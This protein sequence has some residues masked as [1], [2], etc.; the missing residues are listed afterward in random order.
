M[1]TVKAILAGLLV[2][3]ILIGIGVAGWQFDWWLAEKNV[4]RQ[5]SLENK[6][7]GTQTAWKDQARKL[8][9][10]ANLLPEGSPQQ[11][12]VADEACEYIDKLTENYLTNQ[13]AAYEAANC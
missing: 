10:E 7:R 9:R 8:V 6:N 1:S 4:N 12:M 5:V 2:I 3:G 11:R 13:L